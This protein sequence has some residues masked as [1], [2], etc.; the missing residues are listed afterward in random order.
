M[1]KIKSLIYQDLI[2]NLLSAT[3]VFCQCIYPATGTVILVKQRH[4]AYTLSILYVNCMKGI[5][6]R[7]F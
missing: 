4:I 7:V 6:N 5:V 3:Y 2:L 1:L